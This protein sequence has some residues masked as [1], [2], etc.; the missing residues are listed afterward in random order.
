MLH[1]T[2]SLPLAILRWRSGCLSRCPHWRQAKGNL[3]MPQDRSVW[4][5]QFSVALGKLKYLQTCY[6]TLDSKPLYVLE[7]AWACLINVLHFLELKD[8]NVLCPHG[9]LR[10]FRIL[11]VSGGYQTISSM[12]AWAWF[13][14]VQCCISCF[15]HSACHR[16]C[17]GYLYLN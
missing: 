11:E 10:L 12:R 9:I 14:H 2:F 13:Y 5:D 8:K 6:L 15:K 1:H 7:L 4:T 16:V 3:D 17:T